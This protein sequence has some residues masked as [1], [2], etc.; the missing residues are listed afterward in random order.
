MGGQSCAEQ[1]RRTEHLD[2][3]GVWLEERNAWSSLGAKQK[4]VA[5]SGGSPLLTETRMNLKAISPPTFTSIVNMK[6]ARPRM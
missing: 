3:R 5:V 1:N 6:A 2:V 4:R